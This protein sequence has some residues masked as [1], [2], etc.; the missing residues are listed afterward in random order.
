LQ[1]P[2]TK[3]ARCAV[4]EAAR[5]M[6]GLRCQVPNRQRLQ[7]RQGS[8]AL[9]RLRALVVLGLKFKKLNSFRQSLLARALNFVATRY[10]VA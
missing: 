7:R 1:I 5:V 3:S 2:R 4:D 8:L 10:S 6:G 9:L